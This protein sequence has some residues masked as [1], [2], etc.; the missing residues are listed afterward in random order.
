MNEIGVELLL[1]RHNQARELLKSDPFP[2]SE[3]G[4]F[5]RDIDIAIVALKAHHKPF[6]SLP[7]KMPSPGP[8]RADIRGQFVAQPLPAFS[9][10]PGLPRSDLLLQLAKGRRASVVSRP[11]SGLE[12]IGR[13]L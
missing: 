4:M 1:E 12:P 8:L 6:L 10:D 5:R 2:S 13:T 9:N 3:L 11:C 7:T